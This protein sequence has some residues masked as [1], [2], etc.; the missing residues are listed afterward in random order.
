MPEAERIVQEQVHQFMQWQASL[1]AVAT[2]KHLRREAERIRAA[3]FQAHLRKL[4]ALSARQQRIVTAMSHAI[5]N[6]LLHTPTVR[7]KQTS[8]T[9]HMEA[10][11][12]LFD[13]Q[14]ND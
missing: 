13:L 4:G 11:R 8:D 7:L 1:S 6:K 9:Q 2:I 3:E 12:Y 5:V 10:L 14:A